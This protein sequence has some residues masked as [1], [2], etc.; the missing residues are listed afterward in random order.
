[1]GH[2]G[3]GYI[4]ARGFSAEAKVA[5]PETSQTALLTMLEDLIVAAKSGKREIKIINECKEHKNECRLSI[6]QH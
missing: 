1:M 3:H 2:E 5:A 4:V 6:R